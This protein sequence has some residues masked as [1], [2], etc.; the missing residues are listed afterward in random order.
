MTNV[1]M[2]DDCQRKKD[3]YKVKVLHGYGVSGNLKGYRVCLKGGGDPFI[4]EQ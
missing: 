4:G 1:N 2:I 3:D